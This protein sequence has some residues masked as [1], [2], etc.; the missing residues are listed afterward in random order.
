[1]SRSLRSSLAESIHS[2]ADS[3]GEEEFLSSSPFSPHNVEMRRARRGPKQNKAVLQTEFCRIDSMAYCGHGIVENNDEVVPVGFPTGRARPSRLPFRTT[4]AGQRSSAERNGRPPL[5]HQT[6]SNDNKVVSATRHPRGA[7]DY[8]RNASSEAFAPQ[9]ASTRLLTTPLHIPEPPPALPVTPGRGNVHR[10]SSAPPSTGSRAER[11]SASPVVRTKPASSDSAT[12]DE[13][14]A[15]MSRIVMAPLSPATHSSDALGLPDTSAL[16][17][18]PPPR[19]PAS[20]LPPRAPVTFPSGAAPHNGDGDHKNNGH[21][22]QVQQWLDPDKDARGAARHAPLHRERRKRVAEVDFAAPFSPAKQ[23]PVACVC[24]PFSSPTLRGVAAASS[25]LSQSSVQTLPPVSGQCSTDD[26]AADTALLQMVQRRN[27]SPARARRAPTTGSETAAAPSSSASA[28]SISS[29]TKVLSNDFGVPLLGTRENTSGDS[30]NDK[31]TP[32][33]SSLSTGRNAD[34]QVSPTSATAKHIQVRSG[35]RQMPASLQVTGSSTSQAS[36]VP[37]VAAVVSDSSTASSS[38]L[39][40]VATPLATLRLIETG[41]VSSTPRRL[42][43]AARASLSPASPPD[44]TVFHQPPAP[45]KWKPQ[46]TTLDTTPVPARATNTR[47]FTQPS[48]TNGSPS[49]TTATGQHHG[50]GGDVPMTLDAVNDDFLSEAKDEQR[51]RSLDASGINKRDSVRRQYYCLPSVDDI[52]MPG[53]ARRVCDLHVKPNSPVAVRARK[54]SGNK[55]R[56]T[57]PIKDSN[58]DAGWIVVSSKTSP[59][60]PRACASPH[61]P[62]SRGAAFTSPPL[63]NP[64]SVSPPIRQEEISLS[65]VARDYFL[66]IASQVAGADSQAAGEKSQTPGWSPQSERY[67]LP[68]ASEAGSEEEDSEN[69]MEPLMLDAVKV[70]N[71]RIKD[72]K[73]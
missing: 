58:D 59:S 18:A 28:P 10:R 71:K 33:P 41:R 69:Q 16:R 72:G 7:H 24:G 30:S 39:T 65:A 36:A 6:V 3:M 61:K 4:G 64:S 34:P 23:S 37:S 55:D 1:M 8:G 15:P 21:H 44:K 31:K 67:I 73:L 66:D 46:T 35:V 26:S 27:S 5:P 17:G 47:D 42:A 45:P 51:R 52:F 56:D 40:P 14:Y 20:S 60:P 43:N 9:S 11:P 54:G 38:S 19:P 32:T 22:P 53:F 62:M 12:T 29:V 48:L 50:E 13:A 25:P 49:R 57:S 68:E 63:T 2:L 70:F